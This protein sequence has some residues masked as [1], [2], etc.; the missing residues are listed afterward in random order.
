MSLSN[1][2]RAFSVLALAG[3]SDYDLH[4]APVPP[5]EPTSEA[6]LEEP[7]EDLPEPECMVYADR[8]GE[9]EAFESDGEIGKVRTDVWVHGRE[10]EDG[11]W[12]RGKNR[13][14]YEDLDSEIRAVLEPHRKAFIAEAKKQAAR[15]RKAGGFCNLRELH[16]CEGSHW[17]CDQRLGGRLGEITAEARA[18]LT[19]AGFEHVNTWWRADLGRT[20]CEAAQVPPFTYD[21]FPTGDLSGMRERYTAAL[22]EWNRLCAEAQ[23]GLLT[24][25]MVDNPWRPAQLLVE[26]GRILSSG[27][28]EEALAEAQAYWRSGCT[29]DQPSDAPLTAMEEEQFLGSHLLAYYAF[30]E[31]NEDDGH[32]DSFWDCPTNAAFTNGGWSRDYDC[33]IVFQCVPREGAVVLETWDHRLPGDRGVYYS[34]ATGEPVEQ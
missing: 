9:R 15:V 11:K 13:T 6:I 3:C 30:G 4:D 21:D 28:T 19:E 7:E 23:G 17:S 18:A 33:G 34:V 22:A 5:T 31:P 20:E 14:A 2:A 32:D 8:V 27:M 25:E 29:T 12:I 24:T 1:S 16:S 26:R 10:D